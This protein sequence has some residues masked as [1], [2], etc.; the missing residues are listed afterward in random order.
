MTIRSDTFNLFFHD[1]QDVTVSYRMFPILKILRTF[2]TTRYFTLIVV[3]GS[4][5]ISDVYKYRYNFIL[6]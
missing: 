3:V 6:K 4:W 2:R 5:R 1:A